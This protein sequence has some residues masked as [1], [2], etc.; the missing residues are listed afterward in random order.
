MPKFLRCI[1]HLGPSLSIA[2]KDFFSGFCA[3]PQCYV[4]AGARAKGSIPLQGLEIETERGT[5]GLPFR[6][7]PYISM[8]K[9][10]VRQMMNL[11]WK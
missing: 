6:M 10:Y 1:Q 2:L 9:Q 8:L 5:K 4:G 11:K 7:N 3:I